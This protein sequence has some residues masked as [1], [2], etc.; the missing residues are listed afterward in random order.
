MGCPEAIRVEHS[1]RIAS[2]GCWGDFVKALGRLWE[3][4]GRLWGD[5]GRQH[6]GKMSQDGAKMRQAG[7][8]KPALCRSASSR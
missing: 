5:F 6:G 8:N 4:F 1:T 2:E 7:A 3:D